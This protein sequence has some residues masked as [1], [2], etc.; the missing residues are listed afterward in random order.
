MPPPSGTRVRYAPPSAPAPDDDDVEVEVVAIE[1]ADVDLEEDEARNDLAPPRPAPTPL[2][3][4]GMSAL[5]E[6][7]SPW[8]AAG[9]AAAALAKALHA[10]SV[11]IHLL[12]QRR[13]E[14]RTIGVDG[15]RA[16]DLLGRVAPLGDDF[17]AATVVANASALS[18]RLDGGLPRVAPERTAIVR[19]ERSVI[20]V[21]IMCGPYCVGVIEIVDASEQLGGRVDEACSRV[22][23]HLA[24]LF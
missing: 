16:Q 12:D 14:L 17:I 2:R 11:M 20:A 4:D 18:L 6:E 22:S 21:P 7:R 10:R 15:P 19:G 9:I 8:R 24:L 13:D 1:L 23:E 3:L 5:E